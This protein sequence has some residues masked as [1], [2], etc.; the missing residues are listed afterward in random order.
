MNILVAGSDNGSFATS[1]QFTNND[2]YSFYHPGG[3]FTARIDWSGS[4]RADLDL[5]IYKAG[6]TFGDS[7]SIVGQDA[8]ETGT[9]SGTATVSKTL[10]AGT[11]MINVM[12]Y[13][14]GYTS[15]G[16][17]PTSYTLSVGGHAACPIP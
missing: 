6:Y 16:T 4:A 5:Y 12:G 2:F 10:A 13:T 15:T 7:T 9:T 8:A 11:Y 1:N 17:Y 3:T 14:G